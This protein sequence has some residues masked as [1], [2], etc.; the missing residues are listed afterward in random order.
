VHKDLDLTFRREKD[1]RRELPTVL[2]GIIDA[3]E[4]REH[5]IRY[6]VLADI[7]ERISR[8]PYG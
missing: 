3:I 1:A 4:M 8:S 7:A 5:Q 2:L 6:T